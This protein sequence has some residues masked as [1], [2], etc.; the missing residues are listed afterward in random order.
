VASLSALLS[1]KLCFSVLAVHINNSIKVQAVKIRTATRSTTVTLKH[2]LLPPRK[3]V[4]STLIYSW[5]LLHEQKL[6]ILRSVLL[7]C[8]QFCYDLK[9]HVLSQTSFRLNVEFLLTSTLFNFFSASKS[10]SNVASPCKNVLPVKCALS[11]NFACPDVHTCK[12]QI[13]TNQYIKFDNSLNTTKFYFVQ[14]SKI[15]YS[16]V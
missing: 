10:T 14:L 15:N 9:L 13:V 12:K 3:C 7:L 5:R 11:A 16:S 4:A 1:L 8:F 6:F 2:R